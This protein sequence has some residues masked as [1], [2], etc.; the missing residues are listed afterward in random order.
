[1]RAKAASTTRPASFERSRAELSARLR[2][3][4]GEIEQAVLTRAFAVTDTSDPVDLESL[5]PEYLQGLRAAI[6]VAVDFGLEVIERGEERA[7]PPPPVLLAQARL[8][9][10]Y[11]IGLD[12]VL[13]RYS[14]GYVLLTDYLVEEAGRQ[15]L[16]GA[17]LQRLLRAQAVLD[18]L[19]AAVGEEYS[20]EA[21]ERPSSSEERRAE[22]VERLLA[23][24]LLDTSDL[25]YEL[26]CSHLAAI[27]SGEG[28]REA[29]RELASTFGARLLS[30]RREDG[31]LWAWLGSREPLEMCALHRYATERWP[32]GV[33]AV[34][35]EQ[36]EGL[37][38]WRLSHRQAKAALPVAQRSP[39][40]FLRY[41]DVALLAAVLQDELLATSLRKLYLE[42]LEAER[43][44]GK[45]AI[46][47]LRAYFAAG[48]NVSS[49]AAAL[50]VSR[51]A[52]GNRLRAVEATVG[53]PLSSCGPELEAALGL[54]AL[55]KP[56]LGP[57]GF[58]LR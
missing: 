19:L 3:R 31:M 48:R 16:R 8:A 32:A 9:A 26:G 38:G 53:R 57:A 42:P 1:V 15:G 56:S 27:A 36:G 13:R 2:E 11:G 37:E 41:V 20:R 49:A 54:A 39:E 34:I 28:A 45:V 30:V 5:D 18:R 25:A 6:G 17:E 40:P 43:D 58:P 7:P 47:T 33:R 55:R 12:T 22:R 4:R 52:V 46:E 50:G 10:R 14:A 35:G 44:G 24:E 51:Q 29:L 21:A 23:G